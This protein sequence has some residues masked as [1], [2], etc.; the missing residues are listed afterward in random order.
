[1]MTEFF[2]CFKHLTTPEHSR[3]GGCVPGY[4]FQSCAVSSRCFAKSKKGWWRRE[5]AHDLEH[6]TQTL[7]YGG[8]N[9]RVCMAARWTR[10]LLFIYDV[11]YCNRTHWEVGRALLAAQ[12]TDHRASQCKWISSKSRES[13]T[14]SQPSRSCFSVIKYNTECK[15]TQKHAATGGVWSEGLGFQGWKQRKEF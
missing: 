5:T 2:P 3:A 14:Q 10:S 8:G 4:T 9:V 1:M 12:T 13:V 7:R 15:S 6:A 11:T